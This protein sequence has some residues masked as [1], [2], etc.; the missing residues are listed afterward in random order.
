MSLKALGLSIIFIWFAIYALYRCFLRRTHDISLL[1]TTS[2]ADIRRRDTSPVQINLSFLH[3]RAQTTFWNKS[4][5]R[6][7]SWLED[8]H[9]SKWKSFLTQLYGVGCVLGLIGMLVS[10]GLLLWTT[11]NLSVSLLATSRQMWGRPEMIDD[12]GRSMKRTLGDTQVSLSGSSERAF[13]TIKPIVS[14]NLTYSFTSS[15]PPLLLTSAALNMPERSLV[16][17]CPS[18]ISPS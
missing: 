7:V 14:H 6:L 17:R 15:F 4:H 12:V 11:G 2:S 10:L 18:V 1:P 5:D 13:A 16:S 8:K 3:L 9:S